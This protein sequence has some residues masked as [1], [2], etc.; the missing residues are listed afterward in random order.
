MSDNGDEIT[1]I[2]ERLMALTTPLVAWGTTVVREAAEEQREIEIIYQALTHKQ[3]AFCD[4]YLEC[5]NA[6]EAARRAGYSPK[7]AAVMGYE[8]LRKTAIR[9]V[10]E[11][12][13]DGGVTPRRKGDREY[14]IYMIRASN[15]FVKIGMTSNIE[16][17]LS[18]L[19]VFSPLELKVIFSSSFAKK[20]MVGIMEAEIHRLYSDRRMTGE[21][22]DLS[23][24]DINRIRAMLSRIEHES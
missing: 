8:N 21:W 5:L 4:E 24:E 12:G 1:G 16:E 14:C 15:G 13:L 22:F 11:Y 7:T 17:R 18:R 20:A 23:D 10:V 9:R 19:K 2:G 3:Q 6:S